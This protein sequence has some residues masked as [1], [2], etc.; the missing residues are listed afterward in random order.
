MEIGIR[1]GRVAYMASRNEADKSVTW[2]QEGR[3]R[4]METASVTARLR[5][6]TAMQWAGVSSDFRIA[7][8]ELGDDATNVANDLVQAP[9]DPAL[10]Q[11]LGHLKGA[12]HFKYLE[13]R[14]ELFGTAAP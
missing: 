3:Y 5:A 6:S 11:R 2:I 1:T 14:K 7:F 10:L 4:D 12:M 8:G 9:F 13:L